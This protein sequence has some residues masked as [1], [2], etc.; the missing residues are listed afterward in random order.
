MTPAGGSDTFSDKQ[1]FFYEGIRKHHLKKAHDKLQ[2]RIER[3]RLLDSVC[4]FVNFC[5]YFFEL[6]HGDEL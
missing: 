4:N 1:E 5:F 3:E 6:R 2:L